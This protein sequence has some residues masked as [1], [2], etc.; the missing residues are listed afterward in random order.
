LNID[1]TV[2]NKKRSVLQET[3]Y[4]RCYSFE[5]NVA[6]CGSFNSLSSRGQTLF[7]HARARDANHGAKL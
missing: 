2:A 6:Y 3:W 1:I 4:Y 7:I 5:I